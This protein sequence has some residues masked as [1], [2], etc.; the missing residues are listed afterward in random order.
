MSDDEES[1][2]DRPTPPP[3]LQNG[4]P[5]TSTSELAAG[6]SRWM[7]ASNSFIYVELA[8]FVLLLACVADWYP[9][10]SY[11]YALSVACVSLVVCLT[12]QTA[13]FLIPGFLEWVVIAPR[14]ETDSGHTVQKICS[15]VH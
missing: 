14:E 15:A 5:Q 10:A 6:L 11:K 1:H 7:E 9:T 12:L 13:E 3:R 4:S 2:T 8:S